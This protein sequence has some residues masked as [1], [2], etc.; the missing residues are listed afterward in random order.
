M[1]ERCERRERKEGLWSFEPLL[2]LEAYLPPVAEYTCLLRVRATMVSL[3]VQGKAPDR[4][5]RSHCL[6]N[7]SFLCTVAIFL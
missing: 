4:P 2:F 5:P 6:V 3:A 7:S 1:G